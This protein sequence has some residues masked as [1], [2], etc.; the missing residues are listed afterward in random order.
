MKQSYIYE[1]TIIGSPLKRYFYS[2]ANEKK[3]VF[4]YING[5]SFFN[6]WKD[7]D[8]ERVYFSIIPENNDTRVLVYKSDDKIESE[9]DTKIAYITEI[10]MRDAKE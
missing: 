9:E 6:L 8:P 3:E 7:V 1:V 4:R 5:D 2:Y 10:E